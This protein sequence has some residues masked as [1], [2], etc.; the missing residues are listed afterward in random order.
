MKTIY[1][2]DTTCCDGT[3]AA[4]IGFF[5]GV[6]LGHQHLLERLKKE[7]GQHEMH[8]MV[9]TFEHPPRQV[10]QPAWKPALITTLVEKIRLMEHTGI[11][12]L[13]VLRFDR[14]MAALSAR[15]F[16][17]KILLKQLGVRLLLTGYDNRFGHDRTEGFEDYQRYGTEIGLRVVCGDPLAVGGANA[18]SSRIR[19]LLQEGCVEEARRCLG[20]PYTLDGRV[21][22]GQQI[23]RRIGFPTANMK[24]D[25]PC[26]VIPRNGVYAVTAQVGDSP[27]M[28]GIMNIGTRPTFHGE[29]R[30]L[31]TNIFDEL[32]DFYGNHMHVQF[33]SHLRDEQQFASGEVLAEQIRIDKEEAKKRLIAYE[34][35]S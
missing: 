24:L 6:H 29:E 31:E 10:V 9:I 7:A 17:D 12:M 3:F 15:D 4:T 20:R 27:V 32:D 18:S 34:Q 21:V 14:Q 30:T 35:E 19:Q 2:P 23:G 1:Y 8:S 11:D 33:I 26:K 28:R 16:M 5:D 13:V 22:H 25:E